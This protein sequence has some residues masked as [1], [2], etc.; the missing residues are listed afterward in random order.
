MIG[1]A[2]FK[3]EFCCAANGRSAKRLSLNDWRTDAGP[4]GFG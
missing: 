1:N 2:P 3:I 4:D